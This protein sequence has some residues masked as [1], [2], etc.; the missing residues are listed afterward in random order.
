MA[1]LLVDNP[2]GIQ[3]VIQVGEGGGYFDP[4]RVLW[5]ERIHGV[6]DEAGMVSN[7]GGWARDKNGALVFDAA[8]KISSD[9]AK[10]AND[11]K[12]ADQES[13]KDARIAALKSAKSANTPAELKAVLVALVEHLGVE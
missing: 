12:R 11:A 3:E 10:A 9:S 4:E 13:K 5:D 1:K 8:K 7:I 6:M 2:L